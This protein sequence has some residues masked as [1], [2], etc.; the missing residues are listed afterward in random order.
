MNLLLIDDHPMFGV[1]FVHA[2]THLRS[3]IDARSVLH[4]EHGLEM[5]RQWPG[6]DVVL[7]DYRLAGDDGLAGLRRFGMHH[8][9]VAR[10]LI[11][12]QED[13]HLLTQ[14][15]T[16]GA[17]GFLGKSLPIAEILAALEKIVGGGEHFHPTESGNK[18]PMTT[19]APGPTA[20]QLE[21]LMLVARGQQNKQIAHELGIAERTV[22]LHV[23]ALLDALGAR[24]RTH[25]LVLA[26]DSGLI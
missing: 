20:R 15:R 1:G 21:V 12:G 10:V 17:A 8:P 3:G 18:T 16:A 9:L 4:L 6:L 24:N 19:T 25:L 11:S 14:A 23:T 7:I 2:L 5:A 22:K 26:R 13:R